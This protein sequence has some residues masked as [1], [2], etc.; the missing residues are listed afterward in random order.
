MIQTLWFIVLGLMLAGYGVL[1][2]FD[3]G[4]GTLHLLLG[5]S[6]EERTEIIDTIGPIWNGNEVWLLAAGGAMVVAF[7]TLYAAA[8][9]G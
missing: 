7:P 1:D 9:S 2:G 8:F 4:V 6:R 3:L 5:R